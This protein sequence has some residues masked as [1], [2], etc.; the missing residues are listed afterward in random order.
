MKKLRD[1]GH[2]RGRVNLTDKGLSTGNRDKERV[3]LPVGVGS[4]DISERKKRWKKRM[5]RRR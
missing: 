4:M 3:L 1:R 2:C 5:R